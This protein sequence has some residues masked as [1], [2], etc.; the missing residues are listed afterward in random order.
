MTT[1]TAS[2]PLLIGYRFRGPESSGNGGWTCGSLA[3]RFD[4]SGHTAVRV[5]LSAP[6]PL[7]TA[8]RVAAHTFPDGTPGL[9]LIDGGTTIAEAMPVTDELRRIPAQ[10]DDA[11]AAFALAEQAG[12]RFGG[13]TEHPFPSCLACGTARAVGDGLRLRPGPVDAATGPTT[14]TAWVPHPAFDAGD[15]TVDLPTTWAALDCPGGWSA[16]MP[17]R[18]MVLG[19]MTAR[20]LRRPAIG[21]RC[22]VRGMAQPSGRRSVPA[23][24]TLYGADGA[25]IALASQ[26]WVVIGV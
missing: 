4:P 23:W 21:E 13:L 3:Q 10:A 15:G 2:S 1:Q 14:S 11:E 16:E 6:P 8:L 26:I 24:T 22:V 5:R 9:R 20:V 19:T 17:G 7:E 18:P 25:V 12:A